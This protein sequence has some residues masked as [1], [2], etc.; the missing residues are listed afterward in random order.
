MAFAYT[1]QQDSGRSDLSERAVI[2]GDN[3]VFHYDAKA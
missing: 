1:F 3:W 2:C